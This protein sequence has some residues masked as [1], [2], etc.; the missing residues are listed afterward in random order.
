MKALL[1]ALLAAVLVYLLYDTFVAGTAPL[2]PRTGRLCDFTVA[3]SVFEPPSRAIR[4]GIR[5][6]EV[7]LYSDERDQP[8]VAT[9]PQTG[10]SDVAVDNV[11]FESVCIDIANDAFP[12]P[13]PFILS[14]VLHTD[15]TVTIDKVAEHLRTIPR[16]FLLPDKD[17]QTAE[18]SQLANKL[19]LVSGGSVNGTALEPLLN[20]NWS[21]SGVR[22][23]TYQQAIAPRDPAELK[24]FT[25]NGIALVAPEPQFKTIVGNPTEPLAFGCQWNLFLEGPPGFVAKE[26]RTL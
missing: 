9:S 1:L 8:V 2:R 10:G 14:M 5:L 15:R 25:R 7:H 24:R 16:K 26:S 22:R 13:D 20:F 12:S 19:L 17:I 11:S 21:D 23:L 3:G 6:L 4:R 18:I